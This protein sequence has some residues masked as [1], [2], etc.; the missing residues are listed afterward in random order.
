M[1]GLVAGMVAAGA[2]LGAIAFA[3]S[4]SA[5]AF[6]PTPWDNPFTPSCIPYTCAPE[7]PGTIVF[8]Q[9]FSGM[10]MLKLSNVVIWGA[11]GYPLNNL[12]SAVLGGRLFYTN[13]APGSLS[14]D[15]ALN[16]GEA[17]QATQT[18]VGE[19]GFL[20]DPSKGN[21][22]LQITAPI[23]G[24]FYPGPVA[25]EI[26]PYTSSLYW[27]QGAAGPVAQDAGLM[28]SFYTV[29]EP[30]SWALLILG[31]GGMGAALR[32]RSTAHATI[33]APR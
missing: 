29:P 30:S 3:S 20:Y 15:P 4:A 1:R 14:L 21:L 12:S 2:F 19:F 10:P 23:G 11:N 26:Q 32:R 27:L 18:S 6:G 24:P 25:T 31:F 16:I 9:V 22:L 7:E 17:L 33:T 13:A 8:Q 28:I 5:D